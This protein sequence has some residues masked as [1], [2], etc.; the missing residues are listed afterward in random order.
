MGELLDFTGKTIVV[1]GGAS[2]I[3]AATASLAA[4]RGAAVHVLDIAPVTDLPVAPG[5]HGS[6]TGH[7]CDVGDPASID[8]AIGE[9]PPDLAALMNCAG[10]P[11]G[12]RFSPE[13]VMRVNWLGLRHLTEALLPRIGPTGAVVHIASTAGRGWPERQHLHQQLMAATDFDSGLAWLD[14]NRQV[15]GDGYAFS[16]EAVQ[17][18]TL[19][20]SVQLLP[21]G[22]RMNSVCPGVTDTSIVADFRRG[23]G[24]DIIDHAAAVAG[25]MARPSEMAPAM[26]FLADPASSSYVNGVNLN[27]DRGTGAAR[28]TGQSDPIHIWGAGY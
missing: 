19:W 3:G 12:G 27:I 1:T 20:R 11:N 18:Y 22:V 13:Q 10:L 25:R 7:R 4:R 16:K 24:D 5:G 28:A 14:A 26:L 23:L 8:A 21:T 17:Y 15:W 2:G 9:L 6:L